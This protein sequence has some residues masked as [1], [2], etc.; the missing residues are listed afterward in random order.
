MEEDLKPKEPTQEEII[1]ID[2]LENLFTGFERVYNIEDA[3][4]TITPKLILD[5]LMDFYP[6]APFY[7]RHIIKFLID[8]GFKYETL[9]GVGTVWLIRYRHVI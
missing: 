6:S 8:N 9:P 1:L 3:D 4:V 7:I 5:L 2:F